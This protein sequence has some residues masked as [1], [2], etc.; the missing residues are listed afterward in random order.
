MLSV[1]N[2]QL[3]YWSFFNKKWKGERGYKEQRERGEEEEEKGKRERGLI[4]AC[5]L[6]L[7]RY[8]LISLLSIWFIWYLKVFE[9]SQC[10]RYSL[11]ISH[12]N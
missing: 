5:Y 1:I 3:W 2:N 10:D 8:V 9:I 12:I 11:S 7:Y 6:Y 4:G